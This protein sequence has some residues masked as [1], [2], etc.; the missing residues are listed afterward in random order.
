ME[1]TGLGGGVML[2]IA[3]GLWLV[4]LVP[5]WM[6]RREYLATERNAVRLQQTIRVLAETTEAPTQAL[7]RA[8]RGPVAVGRPVAPRQETAP[9]E[10]AAKRLRRTRALAAVVLLA[11]AG[12]GVAQLVAIMTGAAAAS[13]WLVVGGAGLAVVVSLALLG[14][15]AEVSR[16]RRS[17]P[18]QARRGSP[19]VDHHVAAEVRETVQAEWTPVAVPKPL[20]LSRTEAPAPAESSADLAASL[21]RAAEEAAESIRAAEQVPSIRPAAEEPVRPAATGFAAMGIVDAAPTATPDIDAVLARRRA[22][23]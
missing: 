13:G 2:A 22:A 18:A 3:A 21:R 6:K 7:R 4:Y 10:L 15:L 5:T 23:G 19:F 20:Y 16:A 8:P 14:R 9:H 12:V 17:A 1:L 11:S